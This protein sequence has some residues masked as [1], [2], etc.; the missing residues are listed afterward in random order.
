M[1][2]C[3]SGLAVCVCVCVFQ[4]ELATL[5]VIDMLLLFAADVCLHHATIVVL[6]RFIVC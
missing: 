5:V 1:R 3:V 4:F 6:L 2:L